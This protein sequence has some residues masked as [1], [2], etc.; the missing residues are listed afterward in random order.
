MQIHILGTSSS[1]PAHGR[2]VS[3]SAINTEQGIIIVDCGEGF[4]ERVSLHNKKL[5]LSESHFRVKVGR[6]NTILL[7]HGHLDH[8]W[9]LLPFLKTLSLDGRKKPLTIIA[10]T[11]H[12]IV[13][14][15][16]AKEDVC[17]N[18]SN[19]EP[20]NV[21]LCLQFRQWW[22]L[23]GTSELLNYQVNWILI[24]V[25]QNDEIGD[26]NAIL[27]NP[28][29]NT[30][31]PVNNLNQF[32]NNIEILHV[33]TLHSVPS[34][35]WWIKEKNKRGKFDTELA[36]KNNLNS[37][38]IQELA[39]GENIEGHL[40]EEYKLPEQIGPSVLISGDTA[41]K[42]NGFVNFA[43]SKYNTSLLI[44]EAT[45]MQENVDKANEFL[46]S[47]AIQ[48][49]QNA[50]LINAKNLVITHY[51]SR[52]KNT[53]ELTLEASDEF[54]MVHAASDSDIINLTTTGMEVISQL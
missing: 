10:P 31:E 45:F 17:A 5:K 25:N 22:S 46:H 37:K 51:S 26:L 23:G 28:D 21:D 41:G 27:M 50:K 11:S 32:T 24:G 2:S 1:R 14:Q 42:N 19:L 44:H 18:I 13:N 47:T 40:F 12:E 8:T 15:L 16:L 7:T 29:K 3:G 49:A 39:K 33:P 34:C 48:A 36:T 43:K 30:I 4:Q 9:G 38:Q 20:A 35:G 54:E 53:E 6:I 52:I